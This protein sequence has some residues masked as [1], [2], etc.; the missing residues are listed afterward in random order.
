[1][2]QIS[3]FP[4]SNFC[5]LLLF[6]K[7]QLAPSFLSFFGS[8]S[9]FLFVCFFL[10]HIEKFLPRDNY[11]R[12]CYILKKLILMTPKCPIS[13]KNEYIGEFWLYSLPLETYRGFYCPS[14]K[15]KQTMM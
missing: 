2:T 1:M 3:S 4:L 10:G 9:Q 13:K 7:L 8:V 14:E 6:L 15:A 12:V 11:V 5:F